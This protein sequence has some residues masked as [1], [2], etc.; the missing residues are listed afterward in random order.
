LGRLTLETV[1]LKPVGGEHLSV[2]LYLPKLV[3]GTADE[4]LQW[5]VILFAVSV[6]GQVLLM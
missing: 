1:V 6:A 4:D 5:N 2:F 3:S